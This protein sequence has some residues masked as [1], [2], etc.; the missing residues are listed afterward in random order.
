[1]DVLRQLAT[2]YEGTHNFHN[3][4]VGREVKDR[5]NMRYMKRVEVANPVVYGETEWI[6]VLFHGQSFMLHQ[7]RD[8]TRFFL[9]L[10]IRNFLDC[11]SFEKL[12]KKSPMK[13]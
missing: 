11:K 4:T 2:K 8:Y 1:M 5:S 3:F 10:I 6:S 12:L 13:K 9:A 7:V